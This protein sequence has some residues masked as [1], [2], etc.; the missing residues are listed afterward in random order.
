MGFNNLPFFL[1]EWKSMQRISAIKSIY[2]PSE[3][4]NSF[5]VDRRRVAMPW[6]WPIFCRQIRPFAFWLLRIVKHFEIRQD[7]HI[8]IKSPMHIQF[9]LVQ[10]RWMVV[11]AVDLGGW[12]FD[13][14][15]WTQISGLSSFDFDCVVIFA[16]LFGFVDVGA[17]C[18]RLIRVIV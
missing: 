18:H 10:H 1:F 13:L 3:N 15:P 6:S 4:I 9:T 12:G 2:F 5:I 8:I 14:L 16:I 7:P 11:P 17:V